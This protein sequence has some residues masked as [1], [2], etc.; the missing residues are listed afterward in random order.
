[1][2]FS[3]YFGSLMKLQGRRYT[4]VPEFCEGAGFGGLQGRRYP[5]VPEFC[6]G[7]GFG[8]LQGR[9]Y[10]SVPGSCSLFSVTVNAIFRLLW[11]FRESNDG[12]A[13]ARVNSA[14]VLPSL[15][16]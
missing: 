1:M 4:S 7:A 5:S 9:R 12:E 13:A 8:G 6:E 15:P 16:K 10:T 3:V 2:P 11:F 14:P